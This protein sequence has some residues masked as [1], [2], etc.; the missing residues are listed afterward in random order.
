MTPPE[1]SP[2]Q[3]RGLISLKLLLQIQFRNTSIYCAMDIAIF[4]GGSDLVA[5]FYFLAAGND[6]R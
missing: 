4:Q 6:F 2:C 1:P 3:G 5:R